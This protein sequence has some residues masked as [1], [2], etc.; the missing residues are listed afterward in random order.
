MVEQVLAGRD[1]EAFRVAEV[2]LVGE[3][4]DGDQDGEAE[5][6][7]DELAP[8]QTTE[9]VVADVV[10]DAVE[11]VGADHLRAVH[12]NSPFRVCGDGSKSGALDPVPVE[13]RIRPRGLRNR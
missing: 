13:T 10:V 6:P 11:L 12:S 3:E 9:A 5:E 8:V 4:T 7:R 2:V 1:G